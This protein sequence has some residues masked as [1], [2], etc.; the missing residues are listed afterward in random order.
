MKPE[1]VLLVLVT[2]PNRELADRLAD[3][4]VSE[5]L[6]ACVNIIP[7]ISSVYRWKETVQHDEEFL[8]MIKTTAHKF[9]ALKERIVELHTY[10][11]PE[12]L[13]FNASDGLEAYMDWVRQETG[14][15]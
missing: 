8:L 12:V 9:E 4:V 1:N 6:A 14:S 11:L 7:G 3:T 2:V 10:D 13:S 15:S 5:R